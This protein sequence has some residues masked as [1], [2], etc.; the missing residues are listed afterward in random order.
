MSYDHAKQP[1]SSSGHLA[2]HHPHSDGDRPARIVVPELIFKWHVEMQREFV[3]AN[4]AVLRA[5]DIGLEKLKSAC[6]RLTGQRWPTDAE[7]DAIRDERLKLEAV[8]KQA[9]RRACSKCQ[10]TD[11]PHLNWQEYS[12]GSHIRESCSTCGAFRRFARKTPQHVEIANRSPHFEKRSIA[13]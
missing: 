12:G 5:I 9:G 3:T 7:L 11:V 10:S 8:E 6:T 2:L 4:D 1:A 13:R